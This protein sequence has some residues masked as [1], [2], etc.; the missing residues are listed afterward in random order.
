MWI[1]QVINGERKLLLN[2]AAT[3]RAIKGER[4]D[5]T[6]ACLRDVL[7][8]DIEQA[9]EAALPGL[10]NE[11]GR[12]QMSRRDRP[13][14]IPSPWRRADFF[15]S[16]ASTQK[17]VKDTQERSARCNSNIVWISG[18]PMVVLQLPHQPL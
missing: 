4:G 14:S 6:A 11:D 8:F 2:G 5:Q 3:K 12:Q 16:A 7:A 18:E 9:R 15:S 10:Q 13:N 17:R 1:I